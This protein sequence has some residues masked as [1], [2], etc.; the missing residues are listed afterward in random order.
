MTTIY[1]S[2][3]YEDL[4]EYR[5][6]VFEALRK[7]GYKV[8]AM[9]DYVATDRRP[10]EK[11][12]ADVAEADIYVG[13]FAFR[14]GY[15][16]PVEHGNPDRL[17]ITEL[18]FRQ[19]E[20]LRKPCLTFV[21]S[22]DASW[23][24]KFDD[25]RTDK[26]NNGYRI[27]RLREYLLTEKT[28]SPFSSPHQLASLVQA[29]ITKQLEEIKKNQ[30]PSIKE[31]EPSRTITWDIKRDGSPYPGLMHFTRKYAPVF[32]G[33]EAEV[34]EILD[35]MRL[36]EGRFIIISGD[37]GVG[38]SSV[39]DA[40]ILPRLEA[41]GLPGN[42]NCVSVRMLPGQSS[43]PFDA[44]MTVLGDRA[45]R[46]GLHPETIIKELKQSPDT[47]T[48][49]LQKMIPSGSDGKTLVLFLD[50]ME[51][52][53]TTQHI[54]QSNKF[55]TALYRATQERAL[56]VI[57]TIRSDHL[58][59]CHRHPDMLQV[60]RGQGHYPLGRVERFVM[61][62]MIVKPANYAGLKVS[63]NLARH[64]VNDTGSESGNLPLLAFV[65]DQLFKKRS[66]HEL[67]EQVY[68]DLG[69]VGGAIA[70]HVKTV[71]ETIRGQLS[72]EAPEL[73]PKIFQSLVIVNPEGL[74]TRRRPLFAEFPAELRP[75]VDLLV[76]ERLL[77][78]EGGGEKST[79][80]ISH[81][82]LFGA[83]SA[84]NDY[85]QANKKLLMDQTLLENRARKWE[86]MGK[87][88][89]NW[90]ASRREL[91]VFRR[92]GVPTQQAKEY[93]KASRRAV[94]FRYGTGVVLASLF[95]VMAW[96]WREG[97]SVEHTLLKLKSTLTRIHIEP[98]MVEVW[99]GAFRMGNVGGVGDKDEQPAHDVK[100]QKP[101]N[102]GKYEVT[103][104]EYDRF[105]LTTGRSLPGDQGW[106]RGRRP[107]INVS[108]ED[109]VEFA[110]WLSAQTGKH[111]RLPTEA[112][113]EYAARSGG[114]DEIWAGTSI[115]NQLGD[116]AW[117][118]QNSKRQTQPV[119]TRKSNNLEP[120]GLH[121]MSGN[122]WEWVEDCWHQNY[123]DAPSDGRAWREENG[124]QCDLR[125]LRGGSWDNVAV[126][127]CS[128]FR[129][130]YYAGVLNIVI[131][132]RL[133]Q[134]I[135]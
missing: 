12:L 24:R 82:K 114:K 45:T 95:L 37:S 41:G 72:G 81:E 68:K 46:A 38:K 21:V 48:R 103:F 88:R 49:H 16:P 110:K 56:W 71:E 1:L 79:V 52:L 86:E 17:S 80:S 26:E 13:L 47:L 116:Y 43:Q 84:L 124:G 18:E 22:E 42:E 134:D 104:D 109:S 50:Q 55:L 31:P 33:R 69:G 54:E 118:N 20:K 60:L 28:A 101:F 100:I 14:Y 2:S 65:L 61:N 53:F 132:F 129:N 19:A 6:A 122:V 113:W 97:L 121:D 9:E 5:A 27:N 105:A 23:P 87:P 120:K 89:F 117:F 29:A 7:A 4:K 133:A 63:D 64:I 51:E 75:A 91:K 131:G 59:F 34:R 40:G 115:E 92:A 130:K 8:L 128:S 90:L 3:T 102:L 70:E 106:G 35:R 15:V 30:A 62:D 135:D 66:D 94:W 107:V 93:L 77:L 112:E 76:R 111:Y 99:A 126:N 108:W 36:P 11:C 57:A 74:P 67:S 96:A 39:V 125:V 98:E 73:L 58:Q 44:L 25:S 32:F 83:W 78:T 119:G 127:V 10:V 123:I 85:V